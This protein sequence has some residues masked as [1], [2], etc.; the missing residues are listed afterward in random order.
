L[1]LLGGR[2]RGRPARDGE[3]GG[4]TVAPTRRWRGRCF[5]SA[6]VRVAGDAEG[7]RPKGE[8]EGGLREGSADGRS[9]SGAC[10]CSAAAPLLLLAAARAPA[11]GGA[12]SW[13]RGRT[14]ATGEAEGGRRRSL[15][16]GGLRLLE[17]NEKEVGVR[18]L[19]S[20]VRFCGMDSARLSC[21]ARFELHNR[22]WLR[23]LFRMR[24]DS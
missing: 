23:S 17:M 10:F 1:L 22:A 11:G 18:G 12:G 20:A 19:G 4:A 13:G 24:W 9:G 16:L 2:T 21:E 6:S 8:A 5:C 15:G 3:G 14:V 7:R